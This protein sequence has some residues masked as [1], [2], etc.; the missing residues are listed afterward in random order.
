[1]QG[2]IWYAKCT[3]CG[4][5][6]R[7]NP[8]QDEYLSG[9]ECKTSEWIQ[10]TKEAFEEHPIPHY[11]KCVDCGHTRATESDHNLARI[12]CSYCNHLAYIEIDGKAVD[13]T[14]RRKPGDVHFDLEGRPPK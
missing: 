5:K 7:I 13:R 3:V 4:R 14:G 10:I 9:C 12:P 11:W 1:M 6:Q 8:K 2:K